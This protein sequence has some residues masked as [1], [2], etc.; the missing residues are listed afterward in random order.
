MNKSIL[1]LGVLCTVLTSCNNNT[2]SNNNIELKHQGDT[3]FV[4]EQSVINSKIKLQTIAL[5]EYSSEFNAT[6]MVKAIAGQMAEI[7]PLFD[8]RVTKSFVKLGQK[9]NAGSPIFELHSA[10]FSETVKNYYQSLQAKKLKE[11][12]YL[13][14]KDLLKNG[15]SSTKD[16]E[17]AET[18]YEMAVKDY[19]NAVMSLKVL[20]INPAKMNMGQALTVV[21]PIAGEVVQMN[22][23]IGQYVKSD[24]E[25]LAIVAELSKVWVVAQIKEKHIGSIRKEDKVEIRTDANPEQMITGQVAH[26]SELLDE[27][28]RSVQV[29]IVCDNKDRSLKPG[30]FANVHFISFPKESIVIPSTALLQNEEK[31]YV[32]V[33]AEKGKF[34]KREVEAKTANQQE[35]AILNGLKTGDVIVS[36][37]GIYLMEN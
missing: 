3:I 30:M 4:S 20:N 8:G 22:M 6:G 1:I 37:G 26:I 5:Q 23:V 29:L 2:P 18:D 7:S 15:V 9:V 27:E 25:P 35:I 36:E 16:M 12:N 14:Q 13:R 31:S 19:E 32:F 34:V 11:S 28:T 33:Q 17:E 24:G 10:E 21:S